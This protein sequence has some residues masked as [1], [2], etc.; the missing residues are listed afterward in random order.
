MSKDLYAWI[1][2][3]F[4]DKIP[5]FEPAEGIREQLQCNVVMGSPLPCVGAEISPSEQLEMLDSAI[6]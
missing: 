6:F 1:E 3:I 2:K 5:G 4:L